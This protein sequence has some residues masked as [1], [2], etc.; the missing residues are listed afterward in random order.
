MTVREMLSRIDSLELSEQMAYDIYC[1][2]E[3]EVSE[4]KQRTE[5]TAHKARQT[6]Q[7]AMGKG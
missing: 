3:A 1:G 4:R 6:G 5:T 7:K 2:E